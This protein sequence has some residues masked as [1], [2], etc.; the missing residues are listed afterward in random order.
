MTESPIKTGSAEIEAMVEAAR[1]H[2]AAGRAEEAERLYVTALHEAP[3]HWA[4][5][6]NLG[7]LYLERNQP[8]KALSVLEKAMEVAPEGAQTWLSYARALINTGAFLAAESLIGTHAADPRAAMLEVR[9]R[10]VWGMALVRGGAPQSAIVQFQRVLAMRPDDPAAHGDLGYALLAAGALAAAAES[11]GRAADL[12]PDDAGVRLN[13]GSALFKMGRLEDA[14][15]QYRRALALQPG[16]TAA[17]RNLGVLLQK[18]GRSDEAAAL[19]ESAGPELRVLAASRRAEQAASLG[20]HAEALA[21]LDEIV[22]LSPGDL[23]A[24][25]RRGFARLLL[26]DYEGGWRDY[27]IRWRIPRFVDESTFAA[28]LSIASYFDPELS[29]ERLAGRRVLL[30]A[31]QG[32]GDQLLFASMVPDVVEVA[33]EVSLVC[34]RR[35]T[36]LFAASFP[37]VQV[38]GEDTARPRLGDFDKIVALGDLGRLFRNR[39]EEFPGAPYLRPRASVREHWAARLGPRSGALRVGV[40]WRGGVVRTGR[41]ERSVTLDQLAP[42][43]DLPGCEFVNLQ[44]GDVGEELAR[45]NEGRSAPI[46]LFPREEI[47]D[48]E[49]LAGL[50]QNLDVVV[51]VQTALVHLAGALGAPCL[52]LVAHRPEWVFGAEGETTPWSRS[53]KLLR[54]PEPQDWAT[55]I[56][57]AAEMLKSRMNG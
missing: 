52:T 25:Y 38:M 23:E 49:A 53:V 30:I 7:G 1:A 10:Q 5:L 56:G 32:V 47:D 28:N 14:E 54:Q 44:Y 17:A 8:S 41:S 2:H 20:R 46:R 50:V 45:F 27:Q 21:A 43:L 55:P 36:G 40:S 31:E 24:I 35:L 16:N 37:R 22:A 48:F 57:Q 15:A 51:S 39:R 19:A 18:L 29:R 34:E 6:H 11:L 4:A 12:A 3:G 26:G 13:L 9:L 42:I 33:A